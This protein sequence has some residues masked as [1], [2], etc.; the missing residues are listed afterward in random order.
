MVSLLVSY[1]LSCRVRLNLSRFPFSGI[2]IPPFKKA[3]SFEAELVVHFELIY[4][5]LILLCFVFGFCVI[6]LV[7]EKRSM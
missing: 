3:K 1:P 7:S 2:S 4:F 6:G 5:Y